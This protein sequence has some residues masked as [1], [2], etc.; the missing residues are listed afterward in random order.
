MTWRKK[1]LLCSLLAGC[2]IAAFQPIARNRFEHRLSEIFGGRV[3]VGSSKLS[4]FDGTISLGQLVIHTEVD[5]ALD[6][7]LNHN[8]N[9]K[10]GP[11]NRPIQIAYAALRF[12]LH[13]ALFRN[14]KVTNAVATGVDWCIDSP[15]EELLPRAD[16]QLASSLHISLGPIDSKPLK[17]SSELVVDRII[18]PL[19]ILVS[20]EVAKQSQASSDISTSLNQIVDR[21]DEL[22][23]DDSNLNPLR[24]Q[25]VLDN[26]KK[27]L[28]LI[29]Q[30]L[31][32]YRINKRKADSSVQT[33]KQQSQKN[34]VKEL[35]SILTDSTANSRHK[36]QE[37][38]NTTIAK[39]WNDLRGITF[40]LKQIITGLQINSIP[41][42]E[43]SGVTYRTTKEATLNQ[44]PPRITSLSHAKVRGTVHL[45]SEL[46]ESTQKLEFELVL[47]GI[48]NT[49]TLDANQPVVDFNIAAPQ[50]KINP[51]IHSTA[52]I[53]RIPQSNVKQVEIALER[54]SLGS[55]SSRI[56]IHHAEDGWVSWIQIPIALCLEPDASSKNIEGL[57]SARL[58]G[59]TTSNW[60]GSQ[61]MLIELDPTSVDSLESH[62]N[63]RAEIT[64]AKTRSDIL[65][66]GTEKLNNELLSIGSRWDQ[67]GDEHS[68]GHAN[69]EAQ[70]L[71]LNS[72]IKNVETVF[73]RT[74]R[75]SGSTNR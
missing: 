47:K 70:I 23:P 53:S 9:R 60:S 50:D 1:V 36:A 69:W 14:L 32:D 34:F 52:T 58:V 31:A 4:L 62:I 6:G 38:A 37:L 72:R 64:Q 33:L 19:R 41:S 10:S 25:I 27:E 65:I 68:R 66:T 16:S 46:P 71:E 73:K 44:I 17:E 11:N 21:L 30:S 55:M 29:N 57:I 59:K 13:S 28:G 39:H 12:D 22:Q 40:A 35:E 61:S 67:L 56:K 24:Q 51:V 42:S 74:S 2:G 48:S 15:C 43:P 5:S 26:I 3:E 49:M 63:N 7:N 20:E 45:P 54:K 75:N 18:Q 8:I